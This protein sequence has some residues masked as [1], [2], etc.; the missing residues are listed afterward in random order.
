MSKRTFDE[1]TIES[2]PNKG[3]VIDVKID[4]KGSGSIEFVPRVAAT[5]VEPADGVAAVPAAGLAGE[6]LFAIHRFVRAPPPF[7]AN[8]RNISCGTKCLSTRS[9]AYLRDADLVA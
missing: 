1:R 6:L 9:K 8:I 3:K 4:T 5:L 7:A 2:E